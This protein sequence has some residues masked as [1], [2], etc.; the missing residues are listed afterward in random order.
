M[1]CYGKPSENQVSGLQESFSAFLYLEKI[2]VSL[3]FLVFWPNQLCTFKVVFFAYS[4]SCSQKLQHCCNQGVFG[5]RRVFPYLTLTEL[6]VGR[7]T[8]WDA[9]CCTSQSR[10]F[11]VL[12]SPLA[13]PSWLWHKSLR[14]CRLCPRRLPSLPFK[15]SVAY[16]QLWGKSSSAWTIRDTALQILLQIESYMKISSRA[17]CRQLMGVLGLGW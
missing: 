9:L 11:S 17:N 16:R 8:C 7:W 12:S 2:L 14:L 1:L 15:I 10:H 6:K 4:Y 3:R 13:L 5:T